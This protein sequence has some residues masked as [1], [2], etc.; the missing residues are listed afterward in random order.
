MSEKEP[1]HTVNKPETPDLSTEIG[2]AAKIWNEI[3]AALKFK[4]LTGKDSWWNDKGEKWSQKGWEK[5]EEA[6]KDAQKKDKNW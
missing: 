1:I 6:W 4:W 3:K 5:D 2:V